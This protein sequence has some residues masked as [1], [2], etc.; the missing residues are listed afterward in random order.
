M[1]DYETL[2]LIWWALIVLLM[3][4]FALTG[5][6]DLGVA[7]LLPWMG[8]TDDERRVVINTIGP[9]WEGNQTW[10]ITFGAALFAAWPLVY[11]AAFSVL[12]V[13]LIF[14]LFALFLRPVG[15]DYRS[16][17]PDPRWRGAW[18][19][20][21]F[22]GGMFPA[23]V[24]GVAIGNLFLGLPFR[25]D[26]TLRVS[27]HG[28]FLGLFS[29]FTVLTGVLAVAMLAL[30]GAAFLYLRSDA[31]VAER[32]RRAIVIAGGIT[33][34]LFTLLGVWVQSLQ[35]FGIASI[36]D[37]NGVVTPLQKEVVR[38]AG[39]WLANY[40]ALPQLWFVPVA[41]MLLPLLAGF[42]AWLRW[43]WAALAATSGSV[44][45]IIVTAGIALFPFV[46]PSSIDPV[47][48][49]TAWDAVSS[50]KTLTLMLAVV[51][52]FVPLIAL[53]TSWVYRVMRGT[54]TVEQI[55]RETHTSY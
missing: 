21:L 14:T 25:Y 50:Q 31:R 19:W 32:A 23:L 11:A 9:T 4:G 45:A 37:V 16:K 39:L 7:T 42:A 17:L 33:A 20:G 3:L 38:G 26:D 35:G 55:Q 29:G 36:A 27:Y 28:G 22:V 54:V 48:S 41:G 5:G 46:L 44:I 2:K 18:D 53:Y 52:I 6:W 34:A 30:H 24:F 51:A 8:R 12:Y 40:R 13:A 15:F 49:L 10:L 1:L 43:R 47:S